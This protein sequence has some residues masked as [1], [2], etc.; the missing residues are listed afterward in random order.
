M[1]SF[2]DPLCWCHLGFRGNRDRADPD[3]DKAQDSATLESAKAMVAP[4]QEHAANQ[5]THQTEHPV[6][7]VGN[8]M[9]VENAVPPKSCVRRA[10]WH[11]THAYRIY[12]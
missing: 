3:P 8:E 7:S 1:P 2:A 5:V 10:A 11:A 6:L 12:Y 4:C 9:G